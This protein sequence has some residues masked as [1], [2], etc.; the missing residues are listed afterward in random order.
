MRS[1]I[2]EFDERDR[3]A[4]IFLDHIRDSVNEI[5]NVNSTPLLKSSFLVFLYNSIESIS[6]MLFEYIHYEISKHAYADLDEK[7]Q[8]LF[9][10]H[11]FSEKN[12][13]KNKNKLDDMM[14]GSLV[15]PQLEEFQNKRKL[16]SGNI[17][18]MR[19]NKTLKEYNIRVISAQQREYLK[20]IKDKRNK[21]AHGREN[22]M[23]ACRG[24]V[25]AD[26]E[27]MREAVYLVLK[28]MIDNVDEYILNK[29]YLR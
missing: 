25:L 1:I 24:Y 11:H 28:E 7:I 5:G 23:E 15:F 4:R 9:L 17:D 16:F 29:M 2:H 27:E 6:V 8:L 10:S 26:L 13:T 18:G 14:I 19:L 20:T 21:L 22:F 12:W 3:E